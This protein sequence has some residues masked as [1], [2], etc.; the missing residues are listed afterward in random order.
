MFDPPGG[1][2]H[3]SENDTSL[4]MGHA[5]TSGTHRNSEDTAM[6]GKPEFVDVLVIGASLARISSACRLHRN[7]PN[8]GDRET[9][10]HNDRCTNDLVSMKLKP[11][12]YS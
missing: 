6:A 8:S 4:Y 1:K 9:W 12:K 11:S 5:Y 3:Q 10:M 2:T 7:I